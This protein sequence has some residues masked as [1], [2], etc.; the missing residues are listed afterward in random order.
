MILKGFAKRLGTVH[1]NT[2]HLLKQRSVLLPQQQHFLFSTDDGNNNDIKG[3]K[4]PP[5]VGGMFQRK[6]QPN[7]PVSKKPEDNKQTKPQ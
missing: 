1:S 3:T 2:S 4:T 7:P 5:R 6:D